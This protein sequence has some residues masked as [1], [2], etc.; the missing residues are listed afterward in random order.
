[1]NDDEEQLL[2]AILFPHLDLETGP[3]DSEEED[4]NDPE[5][6]DDVALFDDDGL[7]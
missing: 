4:F 1:M 6:F 5:F 7:Q 2:E 3:E